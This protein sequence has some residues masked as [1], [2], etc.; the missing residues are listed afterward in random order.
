MENIMVKLP[1]IN[2]GGLDQSLDIPE[3]GIGILLG[4][5]K[6]WGIICVFLGITYI[7]S[8]FHYN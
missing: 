7:L 5:R 6:Y 3:I 2:F 1:L 4:W 8:Y